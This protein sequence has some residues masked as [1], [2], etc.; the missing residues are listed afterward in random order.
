MGPV[1]AIE[2]LGGFGFREAI[3]A[4]EIAAVSQ[5]DAQVAQDASV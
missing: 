4:A 5:T 2:V 3:E 1:A